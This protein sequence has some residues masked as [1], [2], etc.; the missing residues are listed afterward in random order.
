MVYIGTQ[1]TVVFMMTLIQGSGPPSSI[2]PGI[3]RFVGIT[4]GLAALLAV[5]LLLWPDEAKPSPER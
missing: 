4:G 1:A 3:D 2:M 5:S